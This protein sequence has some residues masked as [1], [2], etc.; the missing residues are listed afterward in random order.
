M[1][2][3][4]TVVTARVVTVAVTLARRPRAVLP[5]SSSLSSAVASGEAVVPLLLKQ[6]IFA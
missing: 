6:L 5:A 4:V 2:L 1:A 3:A